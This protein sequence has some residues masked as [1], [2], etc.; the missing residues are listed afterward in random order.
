MPGA[1]ARGG[2]GNG[3][4]PRAPRGRSEGEAAAGGGGPRGGTRRARRGER[5]RASPERREARGW[6]RAERAEGEPV[7]DRR[8]QRGAARTRVTGARRRR[9]A[10]ANGGGGAAGEAHHGPTGRGAGRSPERGTATRAG[11]RGGADKRE[12][13]AE[14]PRTAPDGARTGQAAGCPPDRHK[15]GRGEGPHRQSTTSEKGRKRGP[16]RAPSSLGIV[17][18]H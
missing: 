16:R 10:E 1:V 14:A 8:G 15:A 18:I 5:T 2:Q 9:Q 13:T 6:P 7:G 17:L 3:A 11:P 12:Q 4:K